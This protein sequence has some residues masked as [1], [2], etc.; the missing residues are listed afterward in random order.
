MLNDVNRVTKITNNIDGILDQPEMIL[1]ICSIC[2]NL[3]TCGR[4]AID[5]FCLLYTLAFKPN[6]IRTL[7]YTLLTSTVPDK[8]QLS[9]SLLSKGIQICKFLFKRSGLGRV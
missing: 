5:V 6:F 9:I 2:H 4:L 1:N 3:L 8:S 7:W